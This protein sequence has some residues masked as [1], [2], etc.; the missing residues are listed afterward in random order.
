VVGTPSWDMSL[1]NYTL[2][3]NP[4]DL[5]FFHDFAI[6]DIAH[7]DEST[8]AI[9]RGIAA[10]AL[11]RHLPLTLAHRDAP[12]IL[13]VGLHAGRH[14]RHL[15]IDHTNAVHVASID[16]EDYEYLPTYDAV[17][18]SREGYVEAG[19]SFH[20]PSAG[21]LRRMA[22]APQEHVSTSNA[23]GVEVR[24]GPP[25]AAARVLLRCV[26]RQPEW[27]TTLAVH[28]PAGTWE[29]A[30]HHL[31]GWGETFLFQHETSADEAGYL[32]PF[33]E[34]SSQSWLTSRD[35][36]L[37]L[38][39]EPALPERALRREPLRLYMYARSLSRQFP[40]L[41]FL[42]YYQVVE[43]FLPTY[44]RLEAAERLQAA[45]ADPEFDP[46]S[47][48][49]VSRALDDV[50]ALTHRTELEQLRAALVRCVD[51]ES[52]RD[53]LSTPD[54]MHARQ[55]VAGGAQPLGTRPLD[56][57]HACGARGPRSGSARCP[58]DQRLLRMLAERVYTLRNRVV[59]AKEDRGRSGPPIFPLTKQ[60]DL[61][62]SEI[63]VLRFA[64]AAV[65]S[66]PSSAVA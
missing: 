34:D 51:A 4:D 37:S 49:S 26:R 11:D 57:D 9:L 28:T 63:E 56:L 14:E 23:S 10:R 32:T 65:L 22:L 66:A 35:E 25:S 45:F 42:A 60:A 17:W 33:A 6:S 44:A 39:R 31:M 46:R 1:D 30:E 61:L 24:L 29:E 8:T 48:D 12:S 54:A 21:H 50:G 40:L 15:W 43:F 5:D 62:S 38:R 7:R 27:A 55:A 3:G 52:F 53:F 64:A 41:Q 13:V 2:A 59:H 19:V 20:H 47:L 18:N 36:P 16:F 58:C